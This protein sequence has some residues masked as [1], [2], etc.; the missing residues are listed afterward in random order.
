MK[1]F[2]KIVREELL[3]SVIDNLD[4]LQFAYRRGKGVNDDDNILNMILTHLKGVKSFVR[5]VFIYFSSAFKLHPAT[6]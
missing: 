1:L 5:L 2:E 6:H 4:S 3:T